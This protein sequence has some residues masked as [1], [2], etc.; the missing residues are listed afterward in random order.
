MSRSGAERSFLPGYFLLATPVFAGLDLAGVGALRVA[1]LPDFS[2]R[3]IYYLALVVLGVIMLRSPRAA[4]WIGMGE[5]AVNVF[6]LMLSVLLPIWTLQE[7]FGAPG[8]EAGAGGPVG[9]EEL[10]ILTPARLLNVAL[11]GGVFI[12]SFYVNK[13]RAMRSLRVRGLP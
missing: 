12:W 7:T 11:S 4:P 3:A 9:T 2:G 5:S 13:H 6:L 10:G 1:A 8:A